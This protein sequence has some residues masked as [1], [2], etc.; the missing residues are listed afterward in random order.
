M[1]NH[2][3]TEVAKEAIAQVK[4]VKID[5]LQITHPSID[6]SIYIYSSDSPKDK[7]LTLEDGTKKTFI[8]L[9]FKIDVNLH[10][11]N[12]NQNLPIVLDNSTKDISNFLK[13]VIYQ[14]TDPVE[15]IYRGYLN[16]DPTTPQIDPL[17]LSLTDVTIDN[18]KVTATASFI[19]F[20]NKIFPKHKYTRDKYPTLI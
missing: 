11:N 8:P 7:I 1:P 5:T 19:D 2:L 18:Y 6:E 15:L 10:N 16:S 20:I 13:K 3:L 14:G 4:D 12:G 9:A 17:I